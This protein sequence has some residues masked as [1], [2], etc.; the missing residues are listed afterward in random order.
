MSKILMISPILTHPTNRGNRARVLD[1]TVELQSKG[2]Q[3][4]F[5]YLHKGKNES[6]VE[7]IDFFGKENFYIHKSK[8][9]NYKAFISPLLYFLVKLKVIS[10]EKAFNYSIDQ[11]YDVSVL[12]LL[13][14]LH[15]KNKYAAVIVEYALLSKYLD[16]FSNDVTKIIDTHDKL[17]ERWKVYYSKGIRPRGYSVSK[18]DEKKGLERADVIIAIQSI[19]ANY[20]KEIC[21][22]R[23]VTYG[24]KIPHNSIDEK[25][26][27]LHNILYIAARNPL[28][29]AAIDW[30]LECIYPLLLDHN[31]SFKITIGGSI[32]SYLDEKEKLP[33]ACKL[34]G[35]I[36]DIKEFYSLGSIVIN[37]ML[38][39]TGL[40]IK[41][42]EAISYKKYLVTTPI[43]CEGLEDWKNQA[44]L[45][46]EDIKS[47]AHKIILIYENSKI[48]EELDIKNDLFIQNWNAVQN[49]EITSLVNMIEGK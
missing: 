40:K 18:L 22:K 45:V 31:K 37:P 15:K 49:Q 9:R 34:L 21:N 46:A 41:S 12:P 17:S 13:K 14:T 10:P 25:Q 8:K 3:I 7:T 44:F 6:L 48:R 1:L 4:D 27:V 20:F 43:G 30:F 29:E 35:Y 36:E 16:S 39:G 11:L 24:F 38:S 5:L 47:F 32:C 33:N 19:E 26:L 28:N 42:I 2:N 23:V